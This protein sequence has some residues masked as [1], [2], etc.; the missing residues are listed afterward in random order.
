MI[1][2]LGRECLVVPTDVAAVAAVRAAI[3]ASINLF[4]QV[5]F[6]GNNAGSNIRE[7]GDHVT[8]EQWHRVI[9]EHLHGVWYFC[10]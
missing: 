2:Q 3:D 4:R 6:V 8:D 1:E 10:R 9:D 5:D 7:E